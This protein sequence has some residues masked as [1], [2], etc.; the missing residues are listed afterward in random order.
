MDILEKI[1]VNKPEVKY[2]YDFLYQLYKDGFSRRLK[3]DKNQINRVSFVAEIRFGFYLYNRL[4][5]LHYD[6][7][8]FGK[9]PDWVSEFESEKILFEVKQLNPDEKIF[10]ERIDK[11]KEDK[12]NEFE[13]LKNNF[14]IR[15]I[16]PYLYKIMQKER[17]YGDL[18]LLENFKLV[19]CIDFS[20]L[21]YEFFTDKDLKHYLNLKNNYEYFLQAVNYLDKNSFANFCNNVAGFL[22]IPCFSSDIFFIENEISLHKLSPTTVKLLKKQI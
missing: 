6:P 3:K 14:S 15:D 16:F 1:F 19:I 13:Q 18:I 9:K 21:K 5:N 10:N 11:V 2:Q 17:T 12:Y 7:N 22:V 8:T 20:N 4:T